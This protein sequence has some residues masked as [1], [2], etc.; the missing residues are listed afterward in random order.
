MGIG[1]NDTEV[2][3]GNIGSAK[4][5]KYAAVGSGVNMTSRIESYTVGGQILISESVR[6]GAGEVLRIDAQRDVLP[7]GSETSLRIYEVGGIAG[8]FN[9]VLEKKEPALVSMLRQVPILYT[10]LDAE[11]MPKK[12]LQGYLVQLS[13]NCASIALV[14]RVEVLT[15]LK[16]NLAD[17]G[18]RLSDKDFYGKV[19]K[20][21]EEKGQIH[22]VHFTSVP[23]EVDSYLQALQKYAAK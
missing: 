20:S 14:G 17:V 23:P 11:D 16:M 22:V 13:K 3:V 7:K 4:R 21:S 1:L 10:A 12:R 18:E 15:D 5:S 2:I 9:L 8:K 19:I 6:Q